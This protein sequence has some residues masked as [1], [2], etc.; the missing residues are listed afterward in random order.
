MWGAA[1]KW[2]LMQ[3]T[4]P[5]LQKLGQRAGAKLADRLFGPEESDEAEDDKPEGKEKA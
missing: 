4:E 5:A 1:V 2:V 3:A